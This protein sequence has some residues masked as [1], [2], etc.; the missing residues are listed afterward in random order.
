MK[1]NRDK[2]TWIGEDDYHKSTIID[3]VAY[4]FY[5]ADRINGSCSTQRIFMWNVQNFEHPKMVKYYNKA[6]KILKLEKLINKCHE[7]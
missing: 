1:L 3:D 6:E 2:G 5:C 7:N 4:H